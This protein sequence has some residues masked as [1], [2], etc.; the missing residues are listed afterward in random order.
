MD[1]MPHNASLF[2]FSKD[3]FLP[4]MNLQKSAYRRARGG[5]TAPSA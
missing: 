4:A 1:P 5:T 2:G 3:V